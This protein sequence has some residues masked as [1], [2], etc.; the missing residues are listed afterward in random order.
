[1][2]REHR[3]LYRLLGDGRTY[4]RSE[5]AAAVYG[6]A[7]R[8]AMIAVHLFLQEEIAQGRV[9]RVGWFRYRQTPRGPAK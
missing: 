1:M 5:I 6:S 7:G 2:S 8:G 9:Q 4:L 3:R